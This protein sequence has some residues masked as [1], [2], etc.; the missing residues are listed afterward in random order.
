VAY[1]EFWIIEVKIFDKCHRVCPEM[2]FLCRI[3]LKIH[4]SLGVILIPLYS[5]RKNF[6]DND[7]AKIIIM[8]L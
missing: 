5:G 6:N 2:V 1:R 8:F 7:S 3:L 4:Q